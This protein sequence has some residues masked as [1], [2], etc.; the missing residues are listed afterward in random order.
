MKAVGGSPNW[1]KIAEEKRDLLGL[2]DVNLYRKENSEQCGGLV[3]LMLR[4][5]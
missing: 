4:K 1:E 2:V 5:S 3:G